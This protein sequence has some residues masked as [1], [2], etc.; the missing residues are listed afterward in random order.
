MKSIRIDKISLTEID[1]IEPLWNALKEHHRQHTID[2]HDYYL[3]STFFKRKA[4][5]LEKDRLSIF[6]AYDHQKPIGFCVVSAINKTSTSDEQS[7]LGQLE[8]L[9]VGRDYRKLGLG[10]SLASKGIAWLKNNSVSSIQL[11]VGQGNEQAISFYQ[12]L[13]FRER[14]TTMQLF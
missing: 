12:K 4:E 7:L 2:Y 5:L 6:V 8:S 1:V 13:G 11:S 14:A 10:V 9:Y 3:Q